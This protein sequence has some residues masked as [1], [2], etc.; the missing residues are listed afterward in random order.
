MAKASRLSLGHN[1][2]T[3]VSNLRRNILAIVSSRPSTS[4]KTVAAFNGLLQVLL[5]RLNSL[6]EKPSS[7]LDSSI[8]FR[9]SNSA[10]AF[11]KGMIDQRMNTGH[12]KFI[13][14]MENIKTT[15]PVLHSKLLELVSKL[16]DEIAAQISRDLTSTD[17]ETG[18]AFN[19]F[20]VH[21]LKKVLSAAS[22]SYLSLNKSMIRKEATVIIQSFLSK[23]E[24]PQIESLDQLNEEFFGS[25]RAYHLEFLKYFESQCKDHE[26]CTL[27]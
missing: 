15:F 10:E 12:R 26:T 6:G 18:L 13:E 19:N 14:E 20:Y 2:N 17:E 23:C 25:L 7:N 9:G 24:I 1:P 11:F 16:S 21:K 22:E 4:F 27:L 3:A 5:S 8:G